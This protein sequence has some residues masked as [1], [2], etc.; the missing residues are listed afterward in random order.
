MLTHFEYGIQCTFS[1]ILMAE[2]P[3]FKKPF[4]VAGGLIM[5]GFGAYIFY[6]FSPYDSGIFPKCPVLVSTGYQC[7]GCGSQRA[8]HDLMH[9]RFTSALSANPFAVL[10][11]PYLLLGYIA[12]WKADSSL[13]WSRLRKSLF[14]LNAIWIILV[15]VVVFTVMR[16]IF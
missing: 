12:E 2:T 13:W 16:N 8:L 5:L 6:S 14:G 9:L 11:I 4:V 3:L 15:M 7:T 1:R 10:A